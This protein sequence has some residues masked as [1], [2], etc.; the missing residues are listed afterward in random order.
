MGSGTDLNTA[1]YYIDP[2]YAECRAYGRIE[3]AITKRKPR[4]DAV[5]RCHG[6]PFLCDADQRRIL[7]YA[8]IDLGFDKL[9]TEYQ[10]NTI[11]GFRVRAIVKDLASDDPGLETKDLRPVLS[12]IATL[13]NVK[14]ITGA[15]G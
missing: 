2:F 6:Y 10:E 9:D 4:K 13:N 1:A 12:N 11:G 15:L 14:S 8:G 5:V 3:Q 7:E